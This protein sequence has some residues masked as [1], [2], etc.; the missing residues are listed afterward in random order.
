MK[1]QVFFADARDEIV[2]DLSAGYAGLAPGSVV[3]TFVYDRARQTATVAD[4]VKL[5]RPVKLEFPVTTHCEVR[6]TGKGTA[7]F[8]SGG[9][10][11]GRGLNVK[12]SVDGGNWSV[13]RE[14][15]ANPRRKD[16]T[17]LAA[18]LDAPVCE[19]TATVVYAAAMTSGAP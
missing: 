10:G 8:L 5:D 14:T 11:N 9:S 17:R 2:F 4:R 1:T 6:E 7:V 19:A 16:V 18:V 13:K 12:M 3:R 15:L